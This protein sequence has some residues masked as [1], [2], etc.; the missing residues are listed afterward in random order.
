MKF[1]GITIAALL[2][3][4]FARAATTDSNNE[5]PAEIVF[6]KAASPVYEA[7]ED[8]YATFLRATYLHSKGALDRSLTHFQELQEAK[9]TH[10]GYIR[11]LF[12]RGD[13]KAVAELVDK[14]PQ[15][16]EENFSDNLEVRLLVAQS[17]LHAG[18]EDKAEELFQAL[19]QGF[20]DN[21]QVAYY[22]IVSYIKSNDLQQ[23]L[24][25]ISDAIKRPTLRSK[26]FLF[27]F[28]RSKIYMMT[29]QPQLALASIEESLKLFPKFDRGW[30]FKAMLLEQQGRAKEAITGYERFLNIVGRDENVEKQLIQLLFSEQQFDKASTYLKKMKSNTPEYFFDLALIESKAKNYVKAIQFIN[31][32]IAL[33]KNFE[34]AKF[35]KIQILLAQKEVGRVVSF[36][37]SWLANEPSNIS[38]LHTFKLLSKTH[39]K[40]ATVIKTLEELVKRGKQSIAMLSVLAD[41][42]QATEQHEKGIRYYTSISLLAPSPGIKSRALF[43]MGYLYFVTGQKELVAST[44]ES[45]LRLQPNHP[46]AYN[47]LAYHYAQEGKQLTKALALV[48]QALRLKPNCHYYLDTKGCILLKLGKKRASR[49]FFKKALQKAPH[50][51][52]IQQH[53][54]LSQQ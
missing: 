25:H 2:L 6:E 28:L 22:T 9:Y 39:V 51:K 26:H 34:K 8:R 29:N 10:E 42:C 52:V 14:N 50:D 30:L 43:H 27:Y 16:F 5:D 49:A 54:R 13:F 17:M 41:L 20:P 37:K 45:A 21:E 4:S 32:A 53:L 18:H 33:N 35:L 11:L 44:L 47:L 31:K 7:K 3:L 15:A 1:R 40:V 48:N 46:S 36:V 38:L 19:S 24:E 23:A 12:D